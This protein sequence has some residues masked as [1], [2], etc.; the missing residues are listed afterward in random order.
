MISKDALLA[1]LFDRGIFRP[2]FINR[3]DAA[4][5]FHPL[6][7]ENLMDNAQLML[8]SLAKNLQEKEIELVIT[9][10]LKQKIVE[11]SYK[12]Q[13]G[14]REMRRVMQDK[15]ENA[16]ADALLQDKIIKG[17]KIEIN[18]ENFGVVVIK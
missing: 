4:I 10:P 3:F 12:P 1:S 14:A 17:N 18:P 16:I 11:L 5:I 2:E 8:A 13:F 15:V 6:S 7:R 9:E